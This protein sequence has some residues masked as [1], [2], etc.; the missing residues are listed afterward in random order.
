[1]LDLPDW[2]Y[3]IVIIVILRGWW[4][5]IRKFKLYRDAL[6]RFE[7]IPGSMSF[8]YRKQ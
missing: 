2:I 6:S 7:R 3:W 8:R 1:M 5:Q 4:G